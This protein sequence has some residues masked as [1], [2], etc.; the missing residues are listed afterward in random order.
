MS[1]T[2]KKGST[3]RRVSALCLTCDKLID[4]YASQNR[5]YC[6]LNCRSSSSDYR[7]KCS[8]SAKRNTNR[9]GELNPNWRGGKTV[10]RAKLMAQ[11][12]YKDWRKAVYERDNYTC[13]ECGVPGSGKNLNADH[14][15]PYA[16]YPELVHEVSNGRTLCIDC[17]KATDTYGWKLFNDIRWGKKCT[18]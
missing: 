9:H 14:I 2:T 18:Q 5:K 7:Y 4:C 15:K 11:Q 10:G 8:V 16:L 1:W 17:H 13:V 12:E 6:S 3:V